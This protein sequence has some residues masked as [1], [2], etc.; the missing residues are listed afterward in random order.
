M[1][2]ETLSA[3][4]GAAALVTLLTSGIIG[5]ANPVQG[6]ALSLVALC[7]GLTALFFVED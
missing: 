3:M 4:F 2:R 1:I 5:A 6:I 7:F